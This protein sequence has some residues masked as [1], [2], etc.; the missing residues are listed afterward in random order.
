MDSSCTSKRAVIVKKIYQPPLPKEYDGRGKQGKYADL[1]KSLILREKSFE[2]KYTTLVNT[3][4]L[5]GRYFDDF[6]SRNPAIA[7]Q[8]KHQSDENDFNLWKSSEFTATGE[9]EYKSAISLKLREILSGSLKSLQKEEIVSLQD[10]YKIVPDKEIVMEDFTPRPRSKIEE[11]DEWEIYSKAIE[12]EASRKGSVLN[13]ELAKHLI[14]G[15]D[16]QYSL[17]WLVTPYDGPVECTP[18]QGQAIENYQLYVRQC[19]MAEYKGL[20]GLPDVEDYP[21]ITNTGLFFQNPKLVQLYND[22]DEGLRPRLF[23]GVK[24]WK[25]IRY[26]VV[27]DNKA[28]R[29][30]P[31]EGFNAEQ[32]ADQVS[33]EIL[34]YMEQRLKAKKV[35]VDPNGLDDVQRALGRAKAGG[36]Y[37]LKEYVSAV[38]FHERLKGLY[39]KAT[40]P[41]E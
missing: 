17:E 9:R 19:A 28:A 15:Y 24:F 10:I 1:L 37:F 16:F 25:E 22:V 8:L 30:W 31:Q 41:T 40:L 18:E 6:K 34:N 7:D 5:F 27:D 20:N 39:E 21:L 32:A 26:E 23:G 12:K 3:L 13:Q 2:G 38:R 36:E 33:Q 35:E 4:G 11:Y 14:L 29:Y